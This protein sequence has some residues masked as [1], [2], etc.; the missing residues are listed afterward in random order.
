M[1]HD[2][3]QHNYAHLNNI[4]RHWMRNNNFRRTTDIIFYSPIYMRGAKKRE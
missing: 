4:S 1:P 2:T 3:D